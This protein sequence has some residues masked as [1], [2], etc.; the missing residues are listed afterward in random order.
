[1]QTTNKN[2][3]H[4][5]IDSAEKRLTSSVMVLTA[6]LAHKH[7]METRQRQ[8]YLSFWRWKP[9]S[10]MMM[11]EETDILPE[12]EYLSVNLPKEHKLL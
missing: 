7:Q 3:Q 8:V 2:I 5:V 6:Y 11:I 9:K 1:M 12:L 10:Y 4:I